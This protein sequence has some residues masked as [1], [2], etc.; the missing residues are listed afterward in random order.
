MHASFLANS[1]NL[2]IADLVWPADI[3]LQIDLLAQIH[4][5]SAGL[6]PGHKQK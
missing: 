1:R 2:S 6:W 5:G 4:L 3:I